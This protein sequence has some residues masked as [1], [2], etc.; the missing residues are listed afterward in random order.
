[1]REKTRI[2]N[3]FVQKFAQFIFLLQIF[4]VISTA[5]LRG[6]PSKLR[7]HACANNKYLPLKMQINSIFIVKSLHI[8]NICSTFAAAK[9]KRS[10]NMDDYHAENAA[11][12]CQK[13]FGTA[14]LDGLNSRPENS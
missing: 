3:F 6:N 7:S 13:V 10:K 11:S 8:S 9:A 12:T 5:T 14:L 2:T 4:V 1:M